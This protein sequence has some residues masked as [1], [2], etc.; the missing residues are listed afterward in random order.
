MTQRHSKPNAD[1]SNAQH[2]QD[3]LM[4]Q[5]IDTQVGHENG[6]QGIRAKPLGFEL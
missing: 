6:V 1:V 5:N 3:P 2:A 4:C